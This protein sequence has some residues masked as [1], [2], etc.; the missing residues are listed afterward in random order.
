M[1]FSMFPPEVNSGLMFSGAGSGPLLSAA[2]A[3]DELA[4]DLESTATQYQTAITN[5]TTGSWLGPSSARMASAAEPYIAWLQSSSAQAAATGAQAKAAAAAYQTAY[6]SMVPLPEIEANRALLTQLVSNNF[7]GQNTGAIATTEANYLEMWIQDALGMDT[8]HAASTTASTLAQ[9]TPAPQ[10]SDGGASSAA[11]AATQSTANSAS[12]VAADS[13]SA[14]GSA[15][16]L[17]IGD[18]LSGDTDGLT[19][20]AIP[21]VVSA[22]AADPSAALLPI[23]EAYYGGMMASMPARMFMSSGSSSA[24]AAS[25]TLASMGDQLVGNIS[26]LVDGKL[27]SVMGGVGG[28]LRSWGSSISAAMASAHQLGGL[29][30]P[31]GWGA[32]APTDMVRAAPT[33][34]AT[35]VA[36][37]SMMHGLPSSPFSQGLMGALAGRGMT[38]MGSRVAAKVMPR[39]PAGG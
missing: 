21:E 27:A 11:A 17:L 2:S 25:N 13:T 38:S 15:L 6:S 10:V 5:L 34:P 16:T 36:A 37:P 31:H 23:Q 29:S 26:K 35:S 4:G 18:L 32:A 39:S 20:T 22:I 3:W 9:P 12:A 24:S 7:L 28:Q 14:L 8:Y 30:V 33:L 1:I 19:T